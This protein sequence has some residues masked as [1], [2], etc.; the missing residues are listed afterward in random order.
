MT[1]KYSPEALAILAERDQYHALFDAWM[2][3]PDATRKRALLEQLDAPLHLLDQLD[4]FLHETQYRLDADMTSRDVAAY[5]GLS[6]SRIQ[7]L[8][9]KGLLPKPRRTVAPGPKSPAWNWWNAGEI[10]EWWKA[11]RERFATERQTYSAP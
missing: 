6:Q 5:T 8:A 9:R 1:D 10:A 3:E 11:N 2:A 4:A 7:A